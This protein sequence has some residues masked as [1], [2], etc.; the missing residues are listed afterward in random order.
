MNRI[1]RIVLNRSLNVC[2]AVSEVATGGRGG[3][4][5]ST[6]TSSFSPALKLS[7]LASACL[8]ALAAMG[9]GSA[10]ADGGAGGGSL[11]V[12]LTTGGAGGNNTAPNGQNG[13]VAPIQTYLL[14]TGGGGG[15]VSA[16]TG[17]GGNGGEGGN[18]GAGGAGGAVGQT[19]GA[20]TASSNV[21]GSAGAVGEKPTD[22]VGN[23]IDGGGGGGGGGG[24]G[25]VANGTSLSVASGVTLA[26]G[27][28][29]EGGKSDLSTAPGLNSGGGGGGGGQGGMGL[30]V[31][32]SQTTVTNA[33]A[34]RG[35]QGGAGGEANPYITVGTN[36]NGGGG[37]GGAGDGGDALIFATPGGTLVNS[38]SAIGGNGGLGGI[39]EVNGT[40]GNGGA[41]V[42]ASN[43]TIVN[44]GTIA[45]GNGGAATVTTTDGGRAGVGGVGVIGA[46]LNVTNNGALS[47][48]IAGDGVQADAVRFTGGVNRLEL[49]AG[50]VVTGNA[51][52]VAGGT[53]TLALGGATNSSFDASQ[54]GP[55]AQYRNFVAFE[56]TGA[57]TWAL[58]GAP[59]GATPWTVNEGRLSIATD[60][61]LGD[62]GSTLTLNG[63]GLQT[64]ADLTVG[65]AIAL[66]GTGGTL[67]TAAG[68]TAIVAGP[69][70]GAGALVKDEAGTL[71]L[72]GANG[73]TGG[74]TV[75]A[76]TLQVGNGG[77]TGSIVGNVVN[78]GTLAFDRSD[79]T[80]FPG[81]VS[82]SGAV[83]QVGTGS[84]T[85]AATNTY[86]GG[87]RVS[88]GTLVGSATSFGSG[89]I[90]D[91]AALVINQPTDATLAN[92]LSGTG[93][94]T[95]NGTGTLRYTG[96]GTA[97]SGNTLVNSGALSV[98]GSLGGGLTVGNG[99]ALQGTGTVGNTTLL[100]GATVAPG[101]G[102]G[103]LN[104]N[105]NLTFAPG[106]RYQVQ[107]TPDGRSDLIRVTGAATLGGASVVVLAADGN[108]NPVTRYT[109]L[110]SGSRVGTFGG[111]TS[112]FAFLDPTLNYIGQDVILSL[113]RNNVDFANVGLTPNQQASGGAIDRANTGTLYNAVV[114]LDAPTA[115]NA[116]D[117]LSGELHASVK[118][119]AIED[120]RFIREASLDR[121]RQ[122]L[123]GIA[124]ADDVSGRGGL[125]ARALH[126]EGRIATDG[127][128][129]RIDRDISGLFIGADTQVDD[130]TRVGVVGGYTRSQVD[131]DARA[132]SADI[133]TYH[134]G[135]YGGKQ[136]GAL[137]LR[138][139]ASYSWSEV[140][141]RRNVAFPGFSDTLRA[142]YD[143][144]T[145]QVFGELGW[146][147]PAGS[148]S[149]EPFVGL[150]HVRL[151]TDGFTEN[152]GVAALRAQ[153][154]TTSTTFS[155]LGVRGNAGAVSLGGVQ[156]TVR[157]MVG[158]RH[159]F[160][161][162]TPTTAAAFA[163][164]SAFIVAGVPI[165]KDVAV[166]EG[167][168]DFA[169]QRNLTLGVSY[170]GQ[171]GNGVQDH[172]V[173]ANLLW[174]F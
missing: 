46:N 59:T 119:A 97:F 51:V 131:L 7:G 130:S 128:A 9:P 136:W 60:A 38:G 64:T 11:P 129:G 73:Y 92:T 172:G 93:T 167:G 32:G 40:S 134:L 17:I 151:K 156:A 141:T 153:G 155:T 143:A 159:A 91:N 145:A 125:W 43:A 54:I 108:W 103:T 157:G 25:A 112:N 162:T 95:K 161:D 66:T 170:S 71:V 146:T 115:R 33:G 61:S 166:F 37:G 138:G 34:L 137:G 78:N 139:G 109:I 76:G 150:A 85:L 99:A 72:T 88:A 75:S 154:D 70:S 44:N 79:A 50:S 31:V 133:D 5:A 23:D 65:R 19:F 142:E 13:N 62:A 56:K 87:T 18:G 168:L 83:A 111:V 90:V 55:T 74:T 163:N 89:A 36:T 39:G 106:S 121:A 124:T 12:A 47:G 82:G 84:T 77:T 21:T 114:Q 41:G 149:L 53:D 81:T 49:Q 8:L 165:G 123:G 48:G 118:S 42:R 10:W 94:V 127:N 22:V 147:V 107:T 113:T 105:G 57:S 30:L 4:S 67:S 158:W 69:I 26:G 101:N 96:N 132:S 140:D 164:Q 80:T 100:S 35:G 160:G 122:S 6:S 3:S 16:Q 28:G 63:G 144:K 52:G 104:V 169:L 152:G 15:G 27:T 1:H 45:G 148:G 102:I 58:T 126:S 24:A 68:T 174:K 20:G 29:G 173:R 116:F 14:G 98:D 120:S 171:V 135:L 110:T 86:T 2:Q 117:Q